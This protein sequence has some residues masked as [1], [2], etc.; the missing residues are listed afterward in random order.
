[1]L[2]N[3]SRLDSVERFGRRIYFGFAVISIKTMNP[4]SLLAQGDIAH[5]VGLDGAAIVIINLT[6]S[7]VFCMMGVT[8]KDEIGA[9]FFRVSCSAFGYG[10][11]GSYVMFAIVS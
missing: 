6:H 8:T 1:L 7:F 3:P 2:L 5:D 4:D 9:F 10:I 11:N